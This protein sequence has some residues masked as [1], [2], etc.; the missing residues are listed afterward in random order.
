MSSLQELLDSY[1]L[2]ADGWAMGHCV[3]TYADRCRR[4]ETIIWSLRLRVKDAEK[5]M[6]TIE[7]NPHRRAII[8]VRSK[9][10]KSVGTRSFEILRQWAAQEKLKLQM[11]VS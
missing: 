5:S 7:V 3:Y 6:A 11:Q 10:N 8:Q 2:Y 9:C 4:G 1:D